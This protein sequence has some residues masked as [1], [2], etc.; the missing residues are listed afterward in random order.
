M[1]SE[2]ERE[3]L[4]GP[5]L[6]GHLELRAALGGGMA[7]GLGTP[8]PNPAFPTSTKGRRPAYGSRSRT[9]RRASADGRASGTGRGPRARLSGGRHGGIIG[10]AKA[11]GLIPSAKAAFET[12]HNSD[13]RIS[14]EF[15]PVLR[16]VGE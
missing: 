8:P 10:M 11:R 15:I 5:E 14:A 7:E 6:R 13:F 16:R 1:P 3:V 4:P 12:L 2:V 9:V